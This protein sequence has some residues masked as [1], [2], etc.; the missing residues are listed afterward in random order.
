[1][2]NITNYLK[3]ASQKYN[4]LWPHTSQNDH[5]Q[6]VYKQEMLERVW[7][8]GNPLLPWWECELV[9]LLWRTV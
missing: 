4:E 8:K 3:N 5:F 1:M 2:L 6:K 9:Q 7:R